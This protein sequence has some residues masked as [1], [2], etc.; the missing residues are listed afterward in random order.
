M[1]IDNNSEVGDNVKI[2]VAPGATV[3]LQ[4]T[5]LKAKKPVEIHFSGNA[6]FQDSTID[7]QEDATVPANLVITKS[8]IEVPLHFFAKEPGNTVVAGI[9]FKNRQTMLDL[10][11]EGQWENVS[12]LEIYTGETVVGLVR[13]DSQ[14]FINRVLT[15]SDFKGRSVAAHF[16]D[17]NSFQRAVRN[18]PRL[19]GIPRI[20]DWATAQKTEF[21]SM[22][23]Y[24]GGTDVRGVPIKEA[25][26][27]F[28]S[29]RAF[30]EAGLT[31]L[32]P[33]DTLMLRRGLSFLRQ[34]ASS[35][36]EDVSGMDALSPES[37]LKA[38]DLRTLELIGEAI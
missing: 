25:K 35:P 9:T 1:A 10:S 14:R 3:V 21:L 22:L 30:Y 27:S 8:V 19:L 12:A 7:F 34:A 38:N 24:F 15:N 33:I 17:E 23:N 32:A 36:D 31:L 26:E 16:A 13:T 37:A 6:M 5:R 2:T 28:A 29:R 20:S 4:N 18:H 11:H